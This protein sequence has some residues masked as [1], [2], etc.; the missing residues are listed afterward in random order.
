MN[1]PIKIKLLREDKKISQEF[2]SHQLGLSQSQY[3]RR[4]NGTVKFVAE[5]IGKLAKILDVS[6]SFIYNEETNDFTDNT[7]NIDN[8]RHYINVSKK[9]IEQYESIL[10]EKDE[11]ILLLKKNNQ[12]I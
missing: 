4:E 10:K 11:I 9:L 1:I 12:K 5:E 8:V 2:V 3:S 6:V 7:I